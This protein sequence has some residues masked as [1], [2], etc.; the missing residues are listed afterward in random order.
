MS[1]LIIKPTSFDGLSL[2]KR[3]PIRDNRGYFIR[4]FCREELSCLGWDTPV[5]Q[6]NL[7]YSAQ[8]GTIRGMHFQHPPFSE[9]KLLLCL[10]GS[11][12]DIVI[13]IRTGSPTFL[14]YYTVILSEENSLGLHIPEGFAHG[15]QTMTDSVE[16]LYF[17]SAVYSPSAEDGLN[18]LDPKLALPWPLPHTAISERDEKHPVL[19]QN[20]KGIQP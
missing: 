15:F 18:P 8:K 16:L 17:H 19:N 4:L 11:I 2:V 14:Q 3:V 7:S 9:K 13:D 5:A 10:K 20:F 12:M 1:K 6:V